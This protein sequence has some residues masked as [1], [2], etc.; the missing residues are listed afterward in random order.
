V[1]AHEASLRSYLRGAFPAVRD[2]DDV[3]QESFLRV[4]KACATQPIRS[5]RAF[6]FTVARRLA[7][8]HVR[9]ERASPIDPVGHLAALAVVADRLDVVED[10]GRRERIGLLAEAIAD[11]PARCREVFLLYK[12]QGLPRREAAARLGLS[13]KTVEV[14]TARA[15]RHCENF[16]RRKGVKGAFADDTR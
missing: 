5:A 15:M 14:H 2:V 8:D 10:I 7:L 1:H 16:F 6:L 9:H 13:E 3:V 4:W 12:V 11:L